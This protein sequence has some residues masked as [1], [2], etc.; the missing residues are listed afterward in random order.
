MI[1]T[2]YSNITS[3][4]DY[5]RLFESGDSVRGSEDNR[6]SSML[7]LALQH[8]IDTRKFEID[9]YW[10]RATYFWA[11]ILLAFASYFSIATASLSATSSSVDLNHERDYLKFMVAS[12]GLVFSIGWYFANRGSKFWQENWER[13]VELL[14]DSIS[15]PLQ[16]TTI[17]DNSFRLVRLLSAYRFSVTRINLVLNLYII[18]IW[19]TLLFHSAADM[20]QCLEP[21]PNF[22]VIAMSVITFSALFCL[23]NKT[24]GK[25]ETSFNMKMKSYISANGVSTSKSTEID[26]STTASS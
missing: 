19:I 24:K 20:I 13:H 15:G 10:K 11:F 26:N 2:T 16:K 4:E 12:I 3:H 17:D 21:C 18:A 5:L 22:N 8:A 1:N 14:E 6:K 9:L 25:D 23:F 7:E